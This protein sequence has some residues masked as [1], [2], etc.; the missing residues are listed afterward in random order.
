MRIE[1]SLQIYKR[2]D[3]QLSCVISLDLQVIDYEANSE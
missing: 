1:S 2:Y 3:L